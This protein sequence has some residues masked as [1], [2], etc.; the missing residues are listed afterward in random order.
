MHP[1]KPLERGDFSEA[2]LFTSR[3]PLGL[4][5]EEI[6]RK[7]M[8]PLL[9]RSA[10]DF[11]NFADR[12]HDALFHGRNIFRREG[13]YGGIVEIMGYLRASRDGQGPTASYRRYFDWIM[14]RHGDALEIYLSRVDGEPAGTGVLQVFGQ[15]ANLVSGYVRP[16][17]R[18]LGAYRVLIKARVDS[19]RQRGIPRV[20]VLSKAH[21][22]AP[23]LMRIGFEKVCEI[24]TLEL[25]LSKVDWRR[26][27]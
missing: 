22:S 19:L 7:G 5:L 13:D 14:A 24:R 17:F 16:K 9:L 6:D 27:E 21:T 10:H 23:I 26:S 12:V 15:S 18:G 2:A 4:N 3:P 1:G 20:V 11:L 8:E 25:K